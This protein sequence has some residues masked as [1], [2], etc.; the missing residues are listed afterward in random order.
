MSK[1]TNGTI[2]TVAV[3]VFGGFIIYKGLPPL[4]KRL[5][6]K[7]GNGGPG[8]SAGAAGA[9]SYGQYSPYANSSQPNQ[10]QIPMP[11]LSG[12]SNFGGKASSGPQSGNSGYSSYSPAEVEQGTQYM[13]DQLN[14]QRVIV[15]ESGN[16]VT[17]D[18]SGGSYGLTLQEYSNQLNYDR[19]QPAP[20]VDFSPSS[21]DNPGFGDWLSTAINKLFGDTEPDVQLY[22]NNAQ[23]ILAQA[24]NQDYDGLYQTQIPDALLEDSGE[25]NGYDGWGN[26]GGYDGG[27]SGGNGGY[28]SGDGGYGSDTFGGDGNDGMTDGGSSGEY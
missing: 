25:P 14:S 23:M 4:L 17:P 27:D 21:P 19:L 26:S 13:E 16:I 28:G 8:G 11:K 15:D 9:N 6:G 24:L 20:N 10:S 1:N 22:D 3:V 5:A 2:I 12:E 18:E 7:G